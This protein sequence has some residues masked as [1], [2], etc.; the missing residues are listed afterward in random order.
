MVRLCQLVE[1]WIEKQVVTEK[2]IPF[3]DINRI[4][5]KL[6]GSSSIPRRK[7]IRLEILLNDILSN[8]YRVTNIVKRMDYVLSGL[9]VLAKDVSDAL[10]ILVRERLISEEQYDALSKEDDL[11]L[12]KVISEIKTT[13]IGRGINFLPRETP[14]L[15]TKLKEWVMDFA[16]DGTAALRQK[17][18]G[19][20]DELLFRKV[21]T[22]QDHKDITP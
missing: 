17:I 19:V 7:L 21:I 5:W 10:K 16:K 18:L 1:T 20:L 8:R 9:N 4:L 14:D 22:K 15:L 13:K 3:D 2:E 11:N 12:D 6:Q